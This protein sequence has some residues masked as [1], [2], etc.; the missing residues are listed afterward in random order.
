MRLQSNFSE[1]YP[2]SHLYTSFPVAYDLSTAQYPT[3]RNEETLTAQ[4][5]A[6]LNCVDKAEVP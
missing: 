1:F 2:T 5:Y 4:T 6:S 3:V